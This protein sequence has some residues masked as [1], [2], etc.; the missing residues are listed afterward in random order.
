MRRVAAHA[1]CLVTFLWLVTAWV[2]AFPME[3]D[4]LDW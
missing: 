2:F 3:H 4:Y 1:I